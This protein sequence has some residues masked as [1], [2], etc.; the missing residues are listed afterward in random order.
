MH[1]LASAPIDPLAERWDATAD[2]CS[3]PGSAEVL[4][5]RIH[6]QRVNRRLLYEPAIHARAGFGAAWSSTLEWVAALLAGTA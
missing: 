4:H 5:R 6:G 1:Y 2:W 3:L